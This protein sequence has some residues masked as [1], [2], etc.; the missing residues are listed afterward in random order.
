[1]GQAHTR[2]YRS[3]EKCLQVC[4]HVLC[5]CP[6]DGSHETEEIFQKH[7]RTLKSSVDLGVLRL[8]CR[9]LLSGQFIF[10]LFTRGKEDIEIDFLSQTFQQRMEVAAATD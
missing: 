5:P 10:N 4:R 6:M 2:S 1:M 8:V 7:G 3:F 9:H